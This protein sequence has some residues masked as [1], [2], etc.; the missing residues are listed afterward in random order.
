MLWLR[1]EPHFD[2]IKGVLNESACYPC[3]RSE[4]DIFEGFF[5]LSS[6]LLTGC[7]LNQGS[8]ILKCNGVVCKV[9]ASRRQ[10]GHSKMS[11]SP[12][13]L[14]QEHGCEALLLDGRGGVTFP[15]HLPRTDYGGINRSLI[16]RKYAQEREY[17]ADIGR[18]EGT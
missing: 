9:H 14:S 17:A 13:A 16:S 1:L 7:N 4:H 5:A 2:R 3:C 8:G 12:L 15:R 11:I 18:G 10:K 6:G